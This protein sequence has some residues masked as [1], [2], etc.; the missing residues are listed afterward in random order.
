MRK[1][2][3]NIYILLQFHQFKINLEIQCLT[4]LNIEIMKDKLI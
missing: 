4:F 1:Y 3:R 2:C